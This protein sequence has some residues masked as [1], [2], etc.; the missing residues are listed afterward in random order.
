MLEI[1]HS[2]QEKHNSRELPHFCF[3]ILT[4]RSTE[5]EKS[6]QTDLSFMCFFG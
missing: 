3:A 1:E 4:T 5:A 6:A 2:K